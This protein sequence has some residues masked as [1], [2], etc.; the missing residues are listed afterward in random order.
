MTIS[1]D[2]GAQTQ[3]PKD[4]HFSSTLLTWFS[5]NGR[6]HLPWQQ[7]VS[8]YRVWISEIMLQQ[9]QV[10]TVV[11]YFLNF[12]KHF[13]NVATLALASMDEVLVLWSGLGYYSRARN[14]HKAAQQIQQ[15]YGGLLPEDLNLL[16]QLPGIGR[17]TAGAIMVLGFSRR[18]AILDGNVKR[19]LARYFGIFGHPNQ[20]AVNKVLWAYAEHLTPQKQV[21]D[22]TQAVM[23]M[24]AV[25][26]TR[27]A[28]TC[29]I[30]PL[31]QGCYA[32][33]HSCQLTLPTPKPKRV[34]PI[35]QTFVMVLQT[36]A[37]VLLERRPESGIWGGL[38]SLPEM[39]ATDSWP[40]W[41]GPIPIEAQ[42]E[43]LAVVKHEF[44]HFKL[45]M[46]PVKL[47]LEAV[48][49]LVSEAA[50][51][52]YQ[53]QILGMPAPIKRYLGDYY[54]YEP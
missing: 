37:G 36:Q 52:W 14:M 45:E 16:Q 28:P 44:T 8:P 4:S 13:P 39:T 49:T 46:T 38:W 33:Q 23:D 48:P 41:L 35:R 27:H 21:V 54:R 7:K 12:I 15:H 26:C 40:N 32:R 20:S 24:G 30:C 18:A 47:Y 3:L 11:P 22:Y 5:Q 34:K 51:T 2:L 6:K 1:H 17:S 43:S 25:L 9:T 53:G 10:V 42:S 29:Q 31:Q 50:L 19:L